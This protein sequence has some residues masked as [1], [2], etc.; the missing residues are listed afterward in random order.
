M[1][2]L[3]T[4]GIEKDSLLIQDKKLLTGVIFHVLESMREETLINS[5]KLLKKY[6]T[7]LRQNFDDLINTISNLK[8]MMG[9]ELVLVPDIGSIESA[10]SLVEDLLSFYTRLYTGIVDGVDYLRYGTKRLDNFNPMSSRNFLESI[11]KIEDVR[12]KILSHGRPKYVRKKIKFDK[13]ME[14]VPFILSDLEAL[15]L[16]FDR[17]LLLCD[18]VLRLKR[19]FKNTFRRVD[20]FDKEINFHSMNALK[21]E[22]DGFKLLNNLLERELKTLRM[23]SKF[24]SIANVTMESLNRNLLV[25]CKSYDALLKELAKCLTNYER[26]SE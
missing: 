15:F 3:N 17:V 9:N 4:F 18:S 26:S 11:P 7:I 8:P 19:L 20:F 21:D 5:G 10:N 16:E 22:E 25:S 24:A 6:D 2:L 23:E 13:F 14:L 1:E 12:M